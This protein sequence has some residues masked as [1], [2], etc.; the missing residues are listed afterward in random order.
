MCT[1]GLDEQLI[2]ISG[3][4]VVLLLMNQEAFKW[5]WF[6]IVSISWQFYA[7]SFLDLQPF[8]PP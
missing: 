2:F 4:T 6:H 7:A 5:C 1:F 3:A 8:L